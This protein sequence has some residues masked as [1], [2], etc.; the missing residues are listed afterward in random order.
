M[1]RRD[2][3]P[4][5]ISLQGFL[6]RWGIK[7]GISPTEPQTT[8]CIQG[9]TR[10]AEK[11]NTRTIQRT[12]LKKLVHDEPQPLPEPKPDIDKGFRV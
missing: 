11:G 2:A 8:T 7:G 10:K 3:I 9:S 4:S 6:E 5:C 1:N 12:N